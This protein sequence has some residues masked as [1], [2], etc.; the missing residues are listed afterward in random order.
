ME[1]NEAF[2]FDWIRK[3]NQSRRQIY[4]D[5]ALLAVG[6]HAGLLKKSN[7]IAPELSH[8][9]RQ[10]VLLFLR[11]FLKSAGVEVSIDG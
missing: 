10:R 3:Y 6:I 5:K 9:E 2:V 4:K 11:E 7:A 1:I 8:E